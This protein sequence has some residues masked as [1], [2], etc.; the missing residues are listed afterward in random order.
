MPHFP[1][2]IIPTIFTQTS[3]TMSQQPTDIHAYHALD[4]RNRKD[5]PWALNEMTCLVVHMHHTCSL[6]DHHLDHYC[7]TGM[8]LNSASFQG[9]YRV[10][11]GEICHSLWVTYNGLDMLWGEW[12]VMAKDLE[13]EIRA[14]KRELEAIKQE[15]DKSLQELERLLQQSKEVVNFRSKEARLTGQ[16]QSPQQCKDVDHT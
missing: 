3:D 2:S 8:C 7:K 11:K 13:K 12:I 6:C 10:D 16:S 5:L 14:A 9:A 15:R 1:S 4:A